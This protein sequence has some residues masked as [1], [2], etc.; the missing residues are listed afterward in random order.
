MRQ[1]HRAGEKLFIDYAGPTMLVVCAF[2][3][4]ISTAQTF[5]V[6]LGASNYTVTEATCSQSLPDWLS[7]NVR[8]FE[9][10][11]GTPVMLI[12]DNLKSGVKKTCRYK[13]ELDPSYQQLINAVLAS[14]VRAA[15]H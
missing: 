14:G 4:E 9:F 5:V 3:G 11:G 1:T 12:P 13:P 10:F 6:V 15:V 7:S 2:S 8:A